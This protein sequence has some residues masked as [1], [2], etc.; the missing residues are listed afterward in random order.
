MFFVVLLLYLGEAVFFKCSEEETFTVKVK[1]ITGRVIDVS[2]CKGTD[3]LSDFMLKFEDACNKKSL[4]MNISKIEYKLIYNKKR[5]VKNRK[6][7]EDKSLTDLGIG[8]DSQL[9]A[10]PWGMAS[11]SDE[12]LT[13]STVVNTEKKYN[14][15]HNT[16]KKKKGPSTSTCP[17]RRCCKICGC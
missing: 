5:I 8:K 9:E 12:K 14:V 4:D 16:T 1:F 13:N 11:K 7:I 17:L 2:G 6:P 3:M 10:I 15:L